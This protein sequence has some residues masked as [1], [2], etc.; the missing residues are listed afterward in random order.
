MV[1]SIF[2]VL[3]M[4]S[5]PPAAK[6]MMSFLCVFSCLAC[7]ERPEHSPSNL[8][9]TIG[10]PVPIKDGVLELDGFIAGGDF[11]EHQSE[12]INSTIAA[13]DTLFLNV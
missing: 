7:S 1:H 5:R 6:V 2:S 13:C 3:F 10:T 9:E 4:S 8:S 11:S 12:A